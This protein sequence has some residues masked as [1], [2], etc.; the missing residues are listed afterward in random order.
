MN[1]R[2]LQ[3][4]D[5]RVQKL[6]QRQLAGPAYWWGEVTDPRCRRGKRWQLPEL[7][8]GTLL[9]M[10]AGCQS[11]RDVESLTEE[12]GETGKQHV[13]R[14]LPDTTLYSLFPRLSCDELRRQLRR[15]VHAHVRAK[16]CEP[17]GLPC[18]VM[19]FDGKGLGALDHDAGG[20][21]QKGVRKNGVPFW[22][23]RVQRATLTSAASKPCVD[24]SVIPADSISVPS[25]LTVRATCHRPGE[26][27]ST[28][29]GR[30]CASTC[31]PLP[32]RSVELSPPNRAGE[33]T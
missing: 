10:L 31:K 2:N 32:P 27:C 30:R 24:Q 28:G 4:K 33:Q 22:L 15:Q 26:K 19:S 9:G 23:S 11:L 18:G 8:D 14:R 16:S 25:V 20:N 13:H 1:L 3:S 12:L 17:E 21:A 6:L 29:S 5:R 7:L